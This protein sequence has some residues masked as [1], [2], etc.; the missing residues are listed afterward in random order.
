[1]TII[2]VSHSV[3]YVGDTIIFRFAIRIL[4]RTVLSDFVGKIVLLT[5]MKS[6]DSRTVFVGITNFPLA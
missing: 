3:R 5:K 4:N 2:T 1:M 6:V